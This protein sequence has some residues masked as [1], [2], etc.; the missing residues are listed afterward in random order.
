MRRFDWYFLGG[1]ALVLCYLLVIW[2]LAAF[3]F[4]LLSD[5]L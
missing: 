4:S 3:S 1:W 5:K 2:A